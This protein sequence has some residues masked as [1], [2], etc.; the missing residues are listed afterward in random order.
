MTCGNNHVVYFGCAGC[1][2]IFFVCDALFSLW[3]HDRQQGRFGLYGLDG[4]GLI[5]ANFRDTLQQFIVFIG[6]GTELLR[7]AVL[8]D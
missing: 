5:P 8:K 1:T 3:P 6:Y 2:F 7:P 4:Q